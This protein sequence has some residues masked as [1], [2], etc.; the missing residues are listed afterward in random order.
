MNNTFC[1]ESTIFQNQKELA[2]VVFYAAGMLGC[3]EKEDSKSV[4]LYCYFTTEGEAQQARDNVTEVIPSSK[5]S[6]Y[7]VEN[8]DWNEKWRESMEPVLL[9]ENIWVSPDW[10]KPPLKPGDKWIQIE[11]K[12][13]FGTGHHE[14]TRL[15]TQAI[16]S[17][18]VSPVVNPS[19]LDIGTG[20]GILCF[21]GDYAGYQ[22]SVG[23]EIDPDCLD[24][25]VENREGN[26]TE[27]VVSFSI[28]TVQ[29]IKEKAAFDTIAMNMLRTHSEPLLDT[30][31]VLLKP[32]GRLV[33]SGLLCVEKDS[34]VN[35]AQS[36]GWEVERET[37]EGEWWCGVLKAKTKKII[38]RRVR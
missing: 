31:R 3:E 6:I 16:L 25:I 22:K 1:L 7:E 38:H 34:V 36:R 9:A 27:S 2:L 32:G 17:I 12:M 26:R 19:L 28:G 30:C 5:T 33:W 29:A 10:L 13:A 24:N 11:P 21:V 23:I 37:T 4:T 18:D 8:R 15:T 20:S 14:T 35:H